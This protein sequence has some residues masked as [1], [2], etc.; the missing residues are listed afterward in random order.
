MQVLLNRL[1]AV[2]VVFSS[3]SVPPVF[4]LRSLPSTTQAS[5]FQ[6]SP[7]VLR[8]APT[9]FGPFALRSRP[10]SLSS[11]VLGHLF[12]SSL[13]RLAYPRLR[14]IARPHSWPLPLGSSFSRGPSSR[15]DKIWTASAPPQPLFLPSWVLGHLPSPSPPS[16]GLPAAPSH[17][18]V[19]LPN[20]PLSVLPWS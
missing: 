18:T 15:T 16:T 5:S 6:Q 17:R 1:Q 11:W 4:L 13:T 8:L 14:L 7:G 12:L 19:A 3:S 20:L 2:P 10:S 9:T